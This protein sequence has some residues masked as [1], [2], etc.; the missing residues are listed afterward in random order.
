MFQAMVR[1]WVSDK[2]KV[3]QAKGRPNSFIIYLPPHAI[4]RNNTL[5]LFDKVSCK[6]T[7]F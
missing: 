5:D 1:M 2:D 3:I 6:N 7:M 4:C